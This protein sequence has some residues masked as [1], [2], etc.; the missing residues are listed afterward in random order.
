[1][2]RSEHMKWCKERAIQEFEFYRKDSL[3]EAIRNGMTSMM[4]DLGKHHETAGLQSL[5]LYMMPTM[6][7]E[8]DFREFI[9][10]F[11]E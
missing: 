2:T 9:R 6:F 1:M 5:V 11:N 7:A 10:G 8:R 3:P 4:S